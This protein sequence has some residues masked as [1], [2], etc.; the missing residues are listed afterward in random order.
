MNVGWSRI[1]EVPSEKT[2]EA[3]MLWMHWNLKVEE[4]KEKEEGKEDRAMDY[5]FTVLFCLKM[6]PCFTTLFCL[7]GAIDYSFAFLFCLDGALACCFPV[8]FC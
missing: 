5:C 6:E 2:K 7:D 8:L 3:V 4:E 1:D